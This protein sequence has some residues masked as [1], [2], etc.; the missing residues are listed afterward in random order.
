M[1]KPRLV[2]YL[3]NLDRRPDRWNEFVK[4]STGLGLPITRLAA[5]D[6]LL[7]SQE[8][9]KLPMPVAACWMSHQMVAEEFL[10]SGAEHCLVLEDD[11]DLDAKAI[12][13]LQNLWQM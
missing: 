7:L 12:L 10:N 8:E 5:V 3:I 9:L 11:I 2:A 13:G 4:K 6:G 1:T